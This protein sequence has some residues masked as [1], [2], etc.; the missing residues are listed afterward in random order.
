[1]TL[2]T[3][4]VCIQWLPTVQLSQQSLLACT[5]L[6]SSVAG[7]CTALGCVAP[8]RPSIDVFPVVCIAETAMASRQLVGVEMR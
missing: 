5:V 3:V 4:L 8:D 6:R 2:I 7:R 1:M